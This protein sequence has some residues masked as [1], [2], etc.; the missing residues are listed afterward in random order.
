MIVGN[1]NHPFALSLPSA[2]DV[3]SHADELGGFVQVS[4]LTMASTAHTGILCWDVYEHL[5]VGFGEIE[6][7]EKGSWCVSKSRLV[8]RKLTGSSSSGRRAFS[9]HIGF[10]VSIGFVRTFDAVSLVHGSSLMLR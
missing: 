2:D 10:L 9:A 1:G 3:G 7:L 4:F 6:S 8:I 5:I